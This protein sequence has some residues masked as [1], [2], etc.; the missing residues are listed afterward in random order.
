MGVC[1]QHENMAD[2]LKCIKN[3]LDGNGR[4]GVLERLSRLETKMNIIIWLNG[5]MA[6]AMIASMLRPLIG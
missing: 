2:D 1:E 3:K 6:S 5:F 4:A